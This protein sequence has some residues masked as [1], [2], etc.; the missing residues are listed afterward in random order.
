MKELKLIDVDKVIA[1]PYQP[2]NHFDE[3]GINELAESIKENGLIQPVSV[4]QKGEY[5]ELV[6][7]ERRFRATQLLGKE[8]IEAYVLDDSEAGSMN[9]ALIENIQRENLSSIEEARAYLKIMQYQHITQAQLAKLVGKS[10][11]SIANK[12]R[13]LQLDEE[14]QTAVENKMIS[15]RHARALL[16]LDEKEQVHFLDKIVKDH[17]TVEQ[18]EKKVK[19]LKEKNKPKHV[20][21][22]YSRN[23]QVALNTVKQAVAM[24]ERTGIC[25]DYSEY[26][27]EEYVTVKLKI[28]K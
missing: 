27:E 11:P 4:R 8:Q 10:Q 3:K 14:V 5:Y 2:R 1:N 16:S 17:M 19:S 21:K 9:K 24:M 25:V 7:G 15:E 12:I 6:V 22:G 20:V 13:L 18:T 23:M 26:D 28:K